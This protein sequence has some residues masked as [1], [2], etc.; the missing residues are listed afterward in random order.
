MLSPP[1]GRETR[2]F[3]LGAMLPPRRRRTTAIAERL[4][5]V[6]ERLLG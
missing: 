3:G 5:R 2:V 1:D 6:D 4:L